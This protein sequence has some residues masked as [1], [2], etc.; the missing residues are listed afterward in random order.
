M[1][2]DCLHPRYHHCRTT[3]KTN[4]RVRST[5]HGWQVGTDEEYDGGDAIRTYFRGICVVTYCPC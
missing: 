3:L 5:E 4:L 1:E 2:G